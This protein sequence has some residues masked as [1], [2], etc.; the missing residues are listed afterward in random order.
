MS[1][2][3]LAPTAAGAADPALVARCPVGCDAAFVDT[4]TVLP[5]GALRR[6]PACGQWASAV[7]VP[8]F[9]ASMKEFDSAAG[10]MPQGA[11]ARRWQQLTGRR[12]DRLARA[13]GCERSKMR[14][15]DVGCSSGSFMVAATALGVPIT[16]VEPAPAAAAA[17][18]ARGLDVRTGTAA[19]ADLPRE[20]FDAAVLIEVIEHVPDAVALLASIRERLRPGGVLL[21]G[22]ANT[23]SW[24]AAALGARWDYLSLASHGG[25]V[26]FFHPGSIALAARRAGFDVLEVRTR[27]VRLAERGDAAY[28]ARKLLAEALAWPARWSGRGHDMEAL[29][30]RPG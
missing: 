22:T 3:H 2:S 18:R 10:T 16:G 12:L 17:A 7:T 5:E 21:V 6:C 23:A 1:G 27:N 20:A 19:D 13:L 14:V 24:T 9:E 8:R 28:R 25:H 26:S 11:A 4:A 15:L 29:L 30:R